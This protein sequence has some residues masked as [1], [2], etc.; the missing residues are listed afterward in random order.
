M[1]AGS[2]LKN[3]SQAKLLLSHRKANWQEEE[4]VVEDSMEMHSSLIT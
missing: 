1:I 3:W 2:L 4:G